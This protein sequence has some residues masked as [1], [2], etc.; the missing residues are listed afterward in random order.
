MDRKQQQHE[1]N[2][3]KQKKVSK[4]YKSDLGNNAGS[5]LLILRDVDLFS[6]V[7]TYII[8]TTLKCRYC[9][10]KNGECKAF[11]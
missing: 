11:E 1:R 9:I 10:D 7:H 3:K 5:A 6:R 8:V 2:E 4:V